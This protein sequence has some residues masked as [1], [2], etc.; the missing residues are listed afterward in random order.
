MKEIAKTL[1][2]TEARVCQI[3]SQAILNLRPAMKKHFER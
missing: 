2:V 3:H 1:G